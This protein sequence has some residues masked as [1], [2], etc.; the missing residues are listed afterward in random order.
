MRKLIAKTVQL[1]L[2]SRRKMYRI[3][4]CSWHVTITPSALTRA[5][6]SR[7][8]TSGGP[9]NFSVPTISMTRRNASFSLLSFTRGEN[10][11]QHSSRALSVAASSLCE[12]EITVMKGNVCTSTR[13]MPRTIRVK[14]APVRW[15]QHKKVPG[16]AIA[17]QSQLST[18]TWSKRLRSQLSADCIGKTFRLIARMW[19]KTA[20]M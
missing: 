10:A 14:D 1:R 18:V 19:P 13:V 9:N 8:R 20:A 3:F 7:A 17:E 5:R 4:D 16:K 6:R 12:R 2:E 11:R 15:L